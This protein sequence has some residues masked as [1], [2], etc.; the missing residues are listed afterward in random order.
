MPETKMRLL[1]RSMLCALP[2]LAYP[3]AAFAADDVVAKLPTV[4]IT[5]KKPDADPALGESRL[6]RAG[7]QRSRSATGDTATLLRNLPGVSLYGA[8]GASSL[9]SLHGLAD[10]RLR[11]KVDGMDLIAS[12][13]NHMNPALSY[14]DPTQVDALQVYAGIA[15]VSLGGDSIGGTIVADTAPP[16]FAA[17]GQASLV[18]GQAG[19]FLRSNGQGGG[20]SLSA[21][22]A[23]ETF[24]ASYAG[25]VRQADN[26]TAGGDFKTSTATGRVDH[27]LPIDEVGS[28]AYK[29]YNHSLGLA[30]RSGAHLVEAKVGLQEVPYQLYPNQRMDMLDNTQ[31]RIN[32]RYRG[33]FDWGSLDARLYH[34]A[35]DHAMDFGADK[36]FWYGA[37][38]GTGAPCSPLGGPPA[39]CAAGMPMNSESSNTGAAL[40]AR[41]ALGDADELHL[42]AELQRYRL[43]DWWP[44]SGGGMWPG[45]FW[46]IADGQRDR[47]ALFAEW[48][49]RRGAQWTTLL[50]LRLEHVKTDA[51]DAVGYSN[52][53]TAMGNQFVDAAAFNA[54]SHARSD[55]NW[56][57]SA[58]AR[59]TLD[60]SRDIEFGFAHKA[61]SPNLYERYTW[62]TWTMAAVMNNFVGDGNGYVG[63]LDLKPEQA[64][65][66]SA[67]FDWHAT[68]RRWA[69][70]ATPYYT[71]VA[72]YVDAIRCVSGA[73]CTAANAS[74]NN[75]FVVLQ[76]ANQSARLWG[77][78]LSGHMPLANTGWGDWGFEGLLGLSRGVNRDTGDDLYNIMPLNTRLTLTHRLGAWDSGVELEMVAAKDRVSE[79][80][81]EV[82]TPGYG[83]LNVRTSYT[84][85]RGRIDFGIDNLFDRFYRLPLGGAYVG[86]GTTMSINGVPWGVAMPGTGRSVHVGLTLEY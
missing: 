8:G 42:G 51:G 69:L 7:L 5:D 82:R 2:A 54:R 32:L 25:A 16:E 81:N 6:D 20:V 77:L 74:A 62:S 34:E 67:S 80:R 19:F 3:G 39:S 72:D 9:P 1:A 38:S 56:D 78:D 57:L 68:D 46:N 49:A 37:L 84:W 55:N 53:P 29:T 83:L 40:K 4:T 28:T 65:T 11:I 10:D 60:A 85:K 48:E 36:R 75:Q 66:L 13:P 17:A 33:R 14:L 41:V 15:P 86:Q 18:K 71:Q 35:V 70:K 30:L 47:S 31:Q 59:Y 12:C 73:A 45:T 43:D 27:T 21:T 26:Y 44:P 22:Y 79:V 58:L 61:R 76:Y 64:D 24:S 23:T 50:G 52:A 63:N